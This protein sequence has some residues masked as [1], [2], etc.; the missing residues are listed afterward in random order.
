MQYK[1]A[2]YTCRYKSRGGWI[3]IG[4]IFGEESRFLSPIHLIRVLLEYPSGK[5]KGHLGTHSEC[6]LPHWNIHVVFRNHLQTASR[7]TRIERT[8]PEKVRVAEL[9]IDWASCTSSIHVPA[10]LSHL[11]SRLKY[12]SIN[13]HIILPYG[14]ASAAVFYRILPQGHR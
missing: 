14:S 4:T 1:A 8:S 11:S 5:P 3:F 13:T 10:A 7:R 2:F 9:Y 12:F 6:A